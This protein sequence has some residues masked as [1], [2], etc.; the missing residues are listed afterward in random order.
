MEG[1][2][3]LLSEFSAS[4]GA[5]LQ[6]QLLAVLG[7]LTMILNAE[8]NVVGDVEVLESKR[9]YT[10]VYYRPC[11]RLAASAIVINR[12]MLGRSIRV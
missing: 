11:T 10:F 3:L 12:K 1:L 7:R 4:T 6:L 5:V 2:S 8:R 9:I